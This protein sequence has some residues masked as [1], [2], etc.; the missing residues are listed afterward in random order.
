M[1]N[2]IPLTDEDRMPWLETLRDLLIEHV[3][4]DDRVVLACSA[5]R[6]NYRD[7]LRTADYEFIPEASKEGVSKFNKDLVTSSQVT[8]GGQERDL[9]SH[10]VF[11]YLKGT[12][13]LLAARLVA[14]DVAG[15]HFMPAT[16]LASQI[17]TLL[18]EEGET[19]VLRVDASLPPSA[20]VEN[21]QKQLLM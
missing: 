17:D 15:T 4:R 14:R 1:R 13:E 5:L 16:L 7:L 18:L 6:P 3:L 10:V 20:I 2:G 21:I 8:E 19:D 12:A 11:V 9:S